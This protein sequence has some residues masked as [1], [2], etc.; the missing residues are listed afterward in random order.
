MPVQDY[1]QLS[2]DTY[3]LVADWYHYAILELTFVNGFK[4]DITWIADKLCIL[5]SEAQEA[6]DRLIRLGLML[7]KDSRLYKTEKFITNYSEGMTSNALKELQR[8]VL[9]MG[10]DAIDDIPGE[11]KDI[12]SM[13]F[14]IVPEKMPEAK[15][16]I[17][18]FRREIS[19]FLER[20]AQQRVYQLGIQLYPVSH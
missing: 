16:R 7:E 18:K 2:L 9:K 6:I 12:T 11:D 20:G 10:L 1:R 4:N 15:Q 5:E 3:A 17:K 14:A 8:N 19:E 13:T